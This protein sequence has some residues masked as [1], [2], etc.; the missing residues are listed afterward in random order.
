MALIVTYCTR[1]ELLDLSNTGFTGV[2]MQSFAS[3]F[4]KS[5]PKDYPL[6]KVNLR[7]NPKLFPDA[8][9]KNAM[10]DFVRAQHKWLGRRSISAITTGFRHFEFD[11]KELSVSE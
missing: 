1:L 7:N 3:H 4:V 6:H 5:V 8:P 11:E 2:A 9:S 10:V